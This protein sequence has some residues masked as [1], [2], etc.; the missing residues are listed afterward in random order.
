MRRAILLLAAL[1]AGASGCSSNS[2]CDVGGTLT[3]YW[4]PPQG[5]FTTATGQLLGCDAAGVATVDVT[6]NGTSAGTFNCHGPSA[7]GIQLTGFGD[8]TVSIQLDAFDASNRHLYQEV[9]RASTALCADTLVDA[10]LTALAGDLTVGYQ[11]TDSFSCT[12]NTFIWYTLLDVA[13]NQVVDEVG[14]SSTNPQAIPC[15]SAITLSALPFGRYTVT[16]I[17]EVQLVSNTYQT[18]HATCSPQ[19]FDHLAAGETQTVLVPPSYGTC[20]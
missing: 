13:Q 15:G 12:A 18:F 3:L 1:A 7:D 19:T 6:V 20:F 16:R 11:F 9:T 14:P 4:Q 17:Q 10:N 2:R 5:G 8:E